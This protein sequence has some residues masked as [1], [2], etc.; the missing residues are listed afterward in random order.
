[1]PYG[2]LAPEAAGL[3]GIVDVVVLVVLLDVSEP[4]GV[5]GDVLVLGEGMVLVE[6]DVVLLGEV[7][8]VLLGVVVVVVL[9]LVSSLLPQAEKASAALSAATRVL[10]RI[11]DA[12]MLTC[13]CWD[14][15]NAAKEANGVP[16]G[17]AASRD[18]PV[19]SLPSSR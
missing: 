15:G 14:K 16:M 19:T 10:R 7:G 11:K 8:D 18:A 1:L 12:C 3:G 6:G 2:A 17:S 5:V 4:L 9:V 13:S